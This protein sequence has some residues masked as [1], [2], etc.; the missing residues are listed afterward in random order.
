MDYSK[1][2]EEIG[3]TSPQAEIYSIL[4]KNPGQKG[5][6][7]LKESSFSKQTV[8]SSLEELEKLD[9][10]KRKE[11]E[12]VSKFLPSHPSKL[13][14]ILENKRKQT[15]QAAHSL[16]SIIK[17]MVSDY[18]LFSGQPGVQV[19]EGEDGVKKVLEDSLKT[20]G[21]ILTYAD[22]EPIVT[23]IK[24]INEDYVKKRLK[25]GIK[26]RALVLNTP[27][28]Q[29]YMKENYTGKITDTRFLSNGDTIPFSAFV[30]IYDDKIAYITFENDKLIGI[31]IQ[32][33]EIAKINKYLFEFA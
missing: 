29:K 6:E 33:P 7:I 18:N 11:N 16:D 14:E 19:F 22:V 24:E 21:E 2:I 8:Y 28:A 17:D 26:K 4:I 31:I 1:K 5:S 3:L 10:V 30:E 20:K 13:L 32:N 9:L 27:F 12:K 23:K 25:L 15:E